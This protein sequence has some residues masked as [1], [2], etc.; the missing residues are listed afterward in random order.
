MGG[1][2]VAAQRVAVARQ[3]AQAERV[4]RQRSRAFATAT[5]T[6]KP[7]QKQASDVVQTNSVPQAP[8]AV[9]DLPHAAEPDVSP[10]VEMP[11]FEPQPESTEDATAQAAAAA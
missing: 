4:V 6:S 3:I 7:V 11:A 2:E 5:S 10:D 8:Q 9:V 1:P